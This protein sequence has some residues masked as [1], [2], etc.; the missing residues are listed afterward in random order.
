[1]RI[2]WAPR[3]ILRA[4]EIAE[5]IAADRPAAAR[6]WVEGLF[7]RAARLGRHARL[8]QKVPDLARDELRQ[9]RY[10]KY[11]IIHRIDPTR[12]VVL[13]VRHY[14]REWDPGDVEPED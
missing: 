2:I 13:T 1:M 3:A 11:R 8:G 12:I 5:Y 10:G 14:A 4:T 6:R 9:L 7:A